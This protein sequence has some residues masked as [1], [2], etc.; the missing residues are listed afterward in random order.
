M[1]NIASQGA[2]DLAAKGD[3]SFLVAFT[4]RQNEGLQEIYVVHLQTYQLR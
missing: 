4:L 2:P 1:R 3:H